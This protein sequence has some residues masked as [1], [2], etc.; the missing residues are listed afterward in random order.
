MTEIQ[1]MPQA[2]ALTQGM[3]RVVGVSLPRAVIAGGLT[4]ADLARLVERCQCCGQSGKCIHWL[5]S[6]GPARALPGY[7]A[8]KAGIEALAPMA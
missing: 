1:E 8:N 5:A 6:S 4:R 3:A 2:W 7:C